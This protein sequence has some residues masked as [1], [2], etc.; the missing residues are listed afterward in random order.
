[1][2]KLSNWSHKKQATHI[3]TKSKVCG[4]TIVHDHLR[5][6]TMHM[7]YV[8]GTL[9]CR[10]SSPKGANARNKFFFG[11]GFC[12]KVFI[13]AHTFSMGFKSGEEAGVFITEL[14]IPACS[15]HALVE[16]LVC[17]ESLSWYNLKPSGNLP[18]CLTNGSKLLS[19]I[20]WYRAEFII[21][22]KMQIGVFP[23]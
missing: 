23:L 7:V 16:R 22:V 14:M 5:Y 18:L 15:I 10:Q 19:R 9:P 8:S 17:L 4:F 11:F 1:M 12:E 20:C 6:H 21:P 3:G 13:P 2:K